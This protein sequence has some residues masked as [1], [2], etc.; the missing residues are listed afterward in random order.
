MA[1][2]D[3]QF[4]GPGLKIDGDFQITSISSGF[5][6]SGTWRPG[7]SLEEQLDGILG[8][9]D[10]EHI[11]DIGREIRK[12]FGDGEVGSGSFGNAPIEARG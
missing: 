3:E 5:T 1:G 2:R 11:A 4:I 6:A 12:E 9:L 7:R 8:P 10:K